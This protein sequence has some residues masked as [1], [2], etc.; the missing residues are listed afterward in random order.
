MSNASR[1]FPV[2]KSHEDH[3]GSQRAITNIGDIFKEPQH[4][5]WFSTL[6]VIIF[7]INIVPEQKQ[8][9]W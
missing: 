5:E 4:S 2:A 6:S 7:E 8:T 3:Q 9:Y 1:S